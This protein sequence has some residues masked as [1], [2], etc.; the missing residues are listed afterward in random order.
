MV[1]KKNGTTG[2]HVWSFDIS[3]E[4]LRRVAALVKGSDIES[5][6]RVDRMEGEKLSYDSNMFDCVTGNCCFATS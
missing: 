2:A 4:Q 3:D 5:R 6:V 1:Y